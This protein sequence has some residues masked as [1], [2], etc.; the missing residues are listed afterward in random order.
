VFSVFFEENNMPVIGNPYRNPNGDLQCDA[1][2]VQGDYAI[3][4]TADHT[5]IAI[6]LFGTVG[7]IAATALT[8][9]D[10]FVQAENRFSPQSKQNRLKLSLAIEGV[11]T[12]DLLEALNETMR[13]I[14]EGYITGA[15]KNDTS[16]F[17]F[18][19]NAIN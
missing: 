14:R 8:P 2:G 16:S 10:A 6:Q 1:K 11:E 9:Q 3:R 7:S 18:L 12:F 5:W 17:N 4:K 15:N 19:I 13:L